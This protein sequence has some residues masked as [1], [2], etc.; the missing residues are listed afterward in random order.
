MCYPDLN[1][2]KTPDFSP[3]TLSAAHTILP[4]GAYWYQT[5]VA[6]KGERHMRDR[7]IGWRHVLAFA[8]ACTVQQSESALAWEEFSVKRESVFEFAQPPRVT[9]DG[10]TVAIMFE[11]KSFCDVTVAI[12]HGDPSKDS[13]QGR[14]IVRHLASGVLGN[15]APP[16]FQKGERK[17]TL[18]WDGKDDAGV[19]VDDKDAVRVR[20]SL[21]LKP[22]FER[23]LFWH[24]WKSGGGVVAMAAAPE[25][26]YVFQSG[27]AV[28]HLRLFDP[29]GNYLRTLYPF[30][31]KQLDNIPGLI[32]H[33]FPDGENIV[34]KPNWQQTSLLMSGSNCTRPTYRNGKYEGYRPRGTE[35]NGAAG[36]A[37]AVQNKRI[38]LVGDRY[39]RLATD[40]SSGGLPLHGTNLAERL[41][42]VRSWDTRRGIDERVMDSVRPKR[43]AFSPDGEWMYLAMFNE[44]HPGSFGSVAWGHRIMRKRFADDSP[45]EP[46]A[47]AAQA[48]Q[49]N[50]QFNMA[51]DVACDSQGRVYAADHGNDRIQVFSPD[52]QHLKNIPVKR[53]AQVDVHPKT[54]EIFVFSWAFPLP[55][56]TSFRGTDPTLPRN[57]ADTF[58]RL[59]KFSAFEQAKEMASWNLQRVAGLRRTR[60]SNVDLTAIVDSWSDPVRVWITSRSP[61]GS[62]QTRGLGVM[63]LTLEDGEWTLNRDFLDE[64]ARAISR[65][66]PARFNRQRLYV[67]PAN[68]MLYLAE[69][70]HAYFKE[71]DRILR[72]DPA[73]G[74]VREIELPL[75]SE[76]MAFDRDG[77]AYLLTAG[78][79]MRY[80]S[81]S[82]REVPFDYGEER[83]RHQFSEGRG[84]RVISGAAF[85][86]RISRNQGGV[87]VAHDGR[88]VIGARFPVRP[89]SRDK[90][91]QV[92]EAEQYQPMLY[93][94]R[95]ASGHITLVQILDRHGRLVEEDAIPGLHQQIDGT[96]MDRH[97]DIYIH[98]A[99]PR[100]IN[101]ERHFNDHAGTLMKFTPGKGRLLTTSGTPIPMSEPPARS[102]DLALPQAWAEGAHWFYGGVGWG[103]HNYSSGCACPN[104]RFALDCFARSFT[105]E[106]DRYNVGVVD[107]AGNLIVRVGQYGNADDGM[108]IVKEGLSS[109]SGQAGPP[110]PRSI[111]PS[112]GASGQASD[113]T[114]IKFAPYVAVHSDRRLF[115]ADPGN[116]RIASVRLGYHT[117]GIVALKDVPDEG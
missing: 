22:R 60:H 94:G 81:D 55:G 30:P 95:R 97:G 69:G 61:V 29:D 115:I 63:L 34:I 31:N 49:E 27:R 25:G 96:A 43:V 47:G 66:H 102:P 86:A 77:Y 1:H 114:A 3:L 58:F 16:P 4:C 57:E 113:E 111:G 19:Y 73:S 74:R 98:S 103:G 70:Q 32:R 26:V 67:N 46:F 117:E 59:T 90:G 83:A 28:D 2:A 108:P 14:R 21:G 13:G 48:G 17:Q 41:E 24:P 116:A 75:G 82:W 80:D 106:I 12:E 93:P 79:I 52:G 76:D 99:Q 68:G 53:P 105:P 42:S 54:G 88:I 15:N 18:I 6:M 20:V 92:H 10:D 38:A 65:V 100:V 112:A 37:L 45:P 107:S 110:S 44:T 85:R 89:A 104:A 84:G 23:S 51:A 56:R 62:R 33:R 5:F 72:I 7:R 91:A 50:G 87:H 35:L 11:T 39:S 78:L 36:Y 109:A 8:A 71:F 64:A 40:G 101:G 9:R